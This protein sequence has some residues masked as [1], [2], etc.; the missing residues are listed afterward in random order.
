[1]SQIIAGHFLLQEEIEQ[2]REA[3][4]AAGFPYERISAFYVN[5]PGQHDL[6]ELGGDREHEGGSNKSGGMAGGGGGGGY[7]A[8]AF[9]VGFARAMMFAVMSM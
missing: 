3:L 1:M 4:I 6:Y 8:E 2:A 7:A 9:N 5:Q